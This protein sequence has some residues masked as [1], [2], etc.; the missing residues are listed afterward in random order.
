V[1]SDT[2]E[3]YRQGAIVSNYADH[4]NHITDCANTLMARDYKG[5]G[6]QSMNAV[7][8]QKPARKE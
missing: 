4:V 3:K 5:F 1:G 8:M 7:I 6:K 2:D